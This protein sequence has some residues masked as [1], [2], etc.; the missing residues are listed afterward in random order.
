MLR[1]ILVLALPAA[2]AA[3]G[4]VAPEGS[5]AFKE[6]WRYGC[7]LGYDHAGLNWYKG[8]TMN[9]PEYGNQPDWK[10]GWD[11]GYRTCFDKALISSFGEN[12]GA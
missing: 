6:G 9:E 11:E 2:L 8:L 3:C 10:V 1:A 5:V 12:N 7:Y 4:S